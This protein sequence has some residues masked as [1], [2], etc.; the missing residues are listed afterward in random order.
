[1]PVP[2]LPYSRSPIGCPSPPTPRP[3]T[4]HVAPTLRTGAPMASSALA[5]LRTS[6]PSSRPAMV[7]RPVASAPNIRARCEIDL[8]PGTRTRPERGRDLA[9]DSGE[10]GAWDMLGRC[11]AAIEQRVAGLSTLTRLQDTGPVP[12]GL[13]ATAG[14]AGGHSPPPVICF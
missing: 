5:V 13:E 12:G 11:C 3:S 8:S 14:A 7:V 6:S 4:S 2:E 9:V 10:D 1:M